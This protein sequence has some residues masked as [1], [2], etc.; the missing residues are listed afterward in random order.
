[1]NTPWSCDMKRC[2]PFVA[3]GNPDFLVIENSLGYE[4]AR[5]PIPNGI[6]D[7]K[8]GIINKNGH[9]MMEYARGIAQTILDGV[10]GV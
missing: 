9:D 5:V 4:V 3:L 8:T 7:T 1:M 6:E 10:N 2:T